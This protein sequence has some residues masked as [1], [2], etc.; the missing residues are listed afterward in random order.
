M[1][2]ITITMDSFNSPYATIGIGTI[3]APSFVA[4]NYKLWLAAHKAYVDGWTNAVDLWKTEFDRY[5]RT[6][7][8][9]E[10][11]RLL[12]S[13]T[14]GNN[15]TLTP[16]PSSSG[17]ALPSDISPPA[18]QNQNNTEDSEVKLFDPATWKLNFGQVA[19]LGLGTFVAYN[20]F[21]RL[22]EGKRR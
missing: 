1:E 15:L 10:Q 4:N 22:R 11:L 8:Y 9:I 18:P 19:L 17:A 21:F 6:Y 13:R 5:T 16:S 12:N 14:P 20:I 3:P 2:R 7:N